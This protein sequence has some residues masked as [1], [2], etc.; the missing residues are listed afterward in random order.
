MI[1]YTDHT[2][3]IFPI[4]HFKPKLACNQAHDIGTCWGLRGRGEEGACFIATTVKPPL[5]AASP[6]PTATFYPPPL[7]QGG[8]CGEVQLYT[9]KC[10]H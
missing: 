1:N 9:R 10:F 3:S 5:T 4:N 6:Q 7:P 8:R 2:V